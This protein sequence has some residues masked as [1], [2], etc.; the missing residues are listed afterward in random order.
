MGVDHRGKLLI[1]FEA[2]PF[3]L[4][5]PVFEELSRP[6]LPVVVPKLAKGLLQHV[7]V[8]EPLVGSQQ[9]LKVFSSVA[10]QVLL[11]GK[12]VHTSAFDELAFLPV[13]RGVFLLSYLVERV[14]QMFQN[15]EL[16]E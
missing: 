4:I 10:L 3:E 14:S 9:N 2:L 15:V 6:G 12:G 8:F 7:G 1:R 11:V 16:I 13:K 5:A